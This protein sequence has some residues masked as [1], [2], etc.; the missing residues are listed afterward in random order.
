MAVRKT[1]WRRYIYKLKWIK[2]QRR[3]EQWLKSEMDLRMINFQ[4]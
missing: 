1:A 2:A 4:L 3:M